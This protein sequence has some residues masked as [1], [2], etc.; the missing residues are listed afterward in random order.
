MGYFEVGI[1]QVCVR[2][3][4]RMYGMN[5]MRNIIYTWANRINIERRRVAGMGE[6]E[7]RY[8]HLASS[9]NL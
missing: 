9:S 5:L 7:L 2:I 4:R 1:F 6:C 8:P 3:Y